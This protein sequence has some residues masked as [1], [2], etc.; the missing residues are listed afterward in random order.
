MSSVQDQEVFSLKGLPK[1]LSYKTKQILWENNK[2]FEQRQEV[3]EH[4]K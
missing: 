1:W 2:L 3:R 4:V